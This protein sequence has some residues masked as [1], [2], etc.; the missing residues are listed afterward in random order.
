[1]SCLKSRQWHWCK[2]LATGNRNGN[3]DHFEVN[4]WEKYWARYLLFCIE[5]KNPAWVFMCVKSMQRKCLHLQ[6][7]A[8]GMFRMLQLW[9]YKWRGGEGGSKGICREEEANNEALFSIPH[10][11]HSCHE[12]F[13]AGGIRL[14]CTD[15]VLSSLVPSAPLPFYP[16]N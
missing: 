6:I 13:F 16:R 2:M 15:L 12:R 3:S 14:V 7:Q 4:Y 5:S 11:K 10:S 9:S 8:E 1:M